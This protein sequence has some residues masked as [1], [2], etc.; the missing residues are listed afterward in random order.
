VIDEVRRLLEYV[1]SQYVVRDEIRAIDRDAPALPN[2]QVLETDKQQA[3]RREE[4]RASTL[5]DSF[6][7]GLV[8]AWQRFRKG[9][10]EIS[11]DDRD[12]RQNQIADALIQFLVRF[13]LA[14]S[15]TEETQPR[16]YT[17]YIAIDWQKLFAEARASSIDLESALNR[18]KGE[19]QS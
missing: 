18:V 8:M 2:G 7:S 3:A 16:R 4:H 1:V 12:P 5:A 19:Q 11:L 15:R 9:G 14:K 10:A 13:D 6:N 17:Y